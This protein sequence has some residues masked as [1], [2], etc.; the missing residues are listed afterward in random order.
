[1]ASSD[2]WWKAEKAASLERKE[3]QSKLANRKANRG[4]TFLIVTEGTVTEPIYFKTLVQDLKLG[5][6]S[7]KVI[8]GRASDPRHVIETAAQVAKDQ[9]RKA[10]S[11]NLSNHDPQ[12]FDH[13]WA[14]IDTDVA[15]RLKFWNDVTQLA[16]A[17]KVKLAHSTPCFEFWLILHY[18]FTTRTDLVN[19]NRAKQAFKELCGEY[20]TNDKAAEKVFS[21]LIQRWPEVVKHAKGVR[22]HHVQA[23]S[24]IPYDPSTDIDLLVE[25]LA[26]S[27]LPHLGEMGS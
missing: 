12:K 27:A 8:P 23:C 15:S 1:V 25:A 5:S 26:H 18:G 9:F 3:A 20:C 21:E 22:E 10:K 17:K 14:V 2:D 13:V 24:V 11:G 16:A 19:G 4:D 6:V 7:V